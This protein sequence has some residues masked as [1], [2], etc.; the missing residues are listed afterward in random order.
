[1]NNELIE[2][3]DAVLELWQ[4]V[5]VLPDDIYLLQD[6]KAALTQQQEA[7]PVVYQGRMRPGWDERGIWAQWENCSKG[8]FEDYKR[9]PINCDWHFESRALYEHPP[10]PA[11]L[12]DNDATLKLSELMRGLEI[13]PASAVNTPAFFYAVGKAI[14]N[15]AKA[16]QPQVPEG[17]VEKYNELLYH[18]ARAFPNESR[19][20]TALRYIKNAE[21]VESYCAAAKEE[22]K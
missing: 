11:A 16:A 2:R 18:V 8:T 14:A 19:H 1:M 17:I 5:T 22:G 3:I 20:E 7:E 15:Q 13:P 9:V 12:P 21:S 10:K 6:C 4:G